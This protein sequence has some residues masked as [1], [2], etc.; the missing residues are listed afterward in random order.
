MFCS[1]CGKEVKPGMKF[2]EECGTPVKIATPEPK[3]EPVDGPLFAPP[4]APVV[5]EEN[6]PLGPWA[7]FGYGILFSLPVVGFILLIVFSFAGRNVN[8]KNFA[9]SYWC[10]LILLLAIVLI[11]VVLILTGVLRGATQGFAYW[12]HSIGLGRLARLFR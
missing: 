11:F 8:R 5:P 3:P 6:R 12:L 7:Y 9:R 4:P 10:W 1:K 2:C